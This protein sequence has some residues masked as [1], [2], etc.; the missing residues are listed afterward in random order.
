MFN[1]R[2]AGLCVVCAAAALPAMGTTE[3]TTA[4]ASWTPML[5]GSPSAQVIE[6]LDG[7]HDTSAGISSD[8]YT[9]IGPDGSG[10]SLTGEMLGGIDGLLGPSD[11]TGYMDVV[12]PGSGQSAIYINVN[13]YNN[14]SLN[15]GPVTLT[16]SDGETFNNVTGQFG[17]SISHP[18]TWYTV[19]TTS[20]QAAFLEWA[21]FGN[22][23]LPQDSGSGAGAPASEAATMALVG[24]GM[25]VL[26]GSKRKLIKRLAAL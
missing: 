20:G 16:L 9:F 17:L 26:F 5:T 19:Q 14:D 22:S 7:T 10:W 21:Y 6:N 24:G 4:Y 2:W 18:I 25:L 12:L 15:N 23:N 1:V 13:T 8:G 3:Q 11:G